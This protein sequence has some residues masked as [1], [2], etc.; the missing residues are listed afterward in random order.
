M[1]RTKSERTN[2]EK[3]PLIQRNNSQRREQRRGMPSSL[4]HAKRYTFTGRLFL[5][6]WRRVWP[7]SGW[8]E[9]IS[10]RYESTATESRNRWNCFG[11]KSLVETQRATEGQLVHWPQELWLERRSQQGVCE[12][13]QVAFA[14]WWSALRP[15]ANWPFAS[16]LGICFTTERDSPC[17]YAS[18]DW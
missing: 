10:N 17:P 4:S 15:L 7:S 14:E 2:S 1:R 13:L 8:I 18:S 9:R 16:R 3:K 11:E 5:E 12:E 6:C